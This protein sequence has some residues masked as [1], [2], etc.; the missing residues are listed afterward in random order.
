[1]NPFKDL[2]APD[3]KEEEEPKVEEEPQAETVERKPKDVMIRSKSRGT[4]SADRSCKKS[5][6]V[7]NSKR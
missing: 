5:S 2:F 4:K 3:E 1:L 7:L 6:Q